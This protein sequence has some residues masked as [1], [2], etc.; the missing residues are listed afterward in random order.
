MKSLPIATFAAASVSLAIA[1]SGG[2]TRRAAAPAQATPVGRV[3]QTQGTV[4][5]GVDLGKV[6]DTHF[7]TSCDRG[8]QQEFDDAVAL[9]HSFFYEEAR[10]RF[11]AVATR[12]PGC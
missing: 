1:C 3:A 5:S 11:V 10:R 2:T 4:R 9:L 6:G 8:L 7:S 12:D